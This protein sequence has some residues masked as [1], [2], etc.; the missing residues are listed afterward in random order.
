VKGSNTVP[1]GIQKSPFS[2]EY[3]D[4]S[5]G[6]Q[7]VQTPIPTSTELLFILIL[8]V[9]V[10]F[11]GEEGNTFKIRHFLFTGTV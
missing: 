11:N 4:L 3:L 1:E 8:Y 2:N 5:S 7:A 6:E 9:V 10:V